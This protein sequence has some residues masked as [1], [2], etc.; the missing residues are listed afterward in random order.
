MRLCCRP[1]TPVRQNHHAGQHLTSQHPGRTHHRFC[2][3]RRRAR[4]HRPR[5]TRQ[6][7]LQDTASSKASSELEALASS[8]GHVSEQEAV[9]SS[10][11]QASQQEAVA[12]SHGK[13]SQLQQEPMASSQGAVQAAFR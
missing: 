1:N 7:A 9:A 8:Q 5:R 13:A 2:R 4:H 3:H 6:Q 11:G 10:E 12:S